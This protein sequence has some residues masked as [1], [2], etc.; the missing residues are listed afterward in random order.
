ML[1]CQ[2]SKPLF[3]SLKATFSNFDAS[4][5]W[6]SCSEFF[7]NQKNEL[8]LGNYVQEENYQG[9]RSPLNPKGQIDVVA[10]VEL[11]DAWEELLRGNAAKDGGQVVDDG[12]TV[13]GPGHLERGQANPV[14]GRGKIKRRLGLCRDVIKYENC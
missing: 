12:E 6:L 9:Y 1:T 13:L 11:L 10:G 5:L 2:K 8:F 14:L 7:F 4:P 3:D